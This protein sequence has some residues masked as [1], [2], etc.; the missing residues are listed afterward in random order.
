MNHRRTK[1]LNY[2]K[3]G[4]S[5][6]IDPKITSSRHSKK[7]YTQEDYNPN[8]GIMTSIWGPPTWHLLHCISFNYP[9]EPTEEQ[10]KQ[11]ASFIKSLRF[12]LPCG[13]CRKNLVKNFR[14]L[15][16]EDKDMVSRETF[17][18]YV[19]DLHEVVN[20]MLGKTSGLKYEDVRDTYEHFR[21]K[22]APPIKKMSAGKNR[23]QHNEKGCVVPVHGK[24]QECILKIQEVSTKTS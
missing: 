4:S 10:K 11:Y 13:K 12:I 21:A 17:S 6:I 24:K 23:A 2:N 5:I 1:K 22:C 14:R 18:K 19:F 3:G 20:H 9:I 15:P 7:N 8:N 16:L